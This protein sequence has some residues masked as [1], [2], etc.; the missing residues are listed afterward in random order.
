MPESA[1]CFTVYVDFCN[2]R[3][4]VAGTRQQITGVPISP[5]ATTTIDGNQLPAPPVKFGGFIKDNAYQSMPYQVVPFDCWPVGMGF[6][7]FFGFVGGDTSQW[8]PDLFRQ[9]TPIDPYVGQPK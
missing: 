4:R 8:Q 6:D 1:Q 3:N 7:Y 2:I 5:Y 9:T